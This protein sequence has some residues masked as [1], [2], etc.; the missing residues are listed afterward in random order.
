MDFWHAIFFFLFVAPL[1]LLW[2]FALFDIFRRHD[3][4]G[5]MKALWLVVVLVFPWIGTLIYVVTRPRG[6]NTGWEDPVALST[7]AQPASV[8]PPVVP[9]SP[10]AAKTTVDQLTALGDL[11]DRGVLTDEEFQQEKEHILAASSAAHAA[12]SG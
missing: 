10:P 12:T 8:S 9:A 5:V 3:L 4:S 2:G 7:S 6:L 11:H 1:L